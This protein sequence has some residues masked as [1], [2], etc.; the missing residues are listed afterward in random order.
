[1]GNNLWVESQ[2]LGLGCLR[3]SSADNVKL[4]NALWPKSMWNPGTCADL[5]TA[6]HKGKAY[7]PYINM[8]T[9]DMDEQI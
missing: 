9:P 3:K 6:D 2:G 4:L 1:M 7:A 5:T 8:L